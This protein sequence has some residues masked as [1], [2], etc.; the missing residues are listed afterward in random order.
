MR[1]HGRP[2]F[3]EAKSSGRPPRWQALQVGD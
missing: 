2:L 3:V 1:S